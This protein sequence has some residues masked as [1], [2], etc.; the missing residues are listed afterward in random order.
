MKIERTLFGALPDGA[1]VDKVTMTNARGASVEILT[2]GGNLLSIR[3]PD[4][5]G[6]LGDV[7]LGYDNIPAI[8]AASGYMGML[9]GRF[10]N[11][12]GGARFELDGKTYS[13]A[14]NDHGNHL[15]GGTQGFDK[16]IWE[17]KTLADGVRLSL[18]S[19]DGDEG[20]PGNMRVTVTYTWNDAN[21]LGLHYEAVCD[22]KTIL[23]LTNHAYFNLSGPECPSIE[24]HDIRVDADAIT[25]VASERC[26]PTGELRPVEGTPFDLRAFRNIGEGLSHQAEDE[27]MTF[28]N[29]YDHNFVLNGSG[30]RLCAEV[31]DDAS[32]RLMKVHTDQPGVQFY[33]G[34]S[35][36]SLERGKAGVP[37]R[38]RQGLCL[39][40]QTFP[41]G[42]HHPNFPSCVLL[43]GA[44][45]ES[46]TFFAFE[47]Y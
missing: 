14:G 5:K 26:I 28:G 36:N 10:A 38:F 11:R 21:E 19:P 30:L 31:R 22:Q 25:A 46:R 23:N 41:D 6:T 12:I 9:I 44:K 37:Y 34:N 35:I 8:R 40:T 18:T 13:L 24:G 2:L 45:F 1:A 3:V 17:A 43:P 20:Y 29:G 47:T 32:G 7:T 42:I 33:C 4:R 15:H 27:Q 16:K 39:E